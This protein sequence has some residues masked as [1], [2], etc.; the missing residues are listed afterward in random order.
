[1][2]AITVRGLSSSTLSHQP[3]MKCANTK[4]FS[5]SDSD[6]FDYSIS[7]SFHG[8]Y[9]HVSVSVCVCF[10]FLELCFFFTLTTI[11][12]FLFIGAAFVLSNVILWRIFMYSNEFQV[13]LYQNWTHVIFIFIYYL[14][15]KIHVDGLHISIS[16]IEIYVYSMQFSQFCLG[17]GLQA[18]GMCVSMHNDLAILINLF[19]VCYIFSTTHM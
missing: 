12:F 9:I 5:F 18:R 13:D 2:L 17:Y 10:F 1:M 3:A 4:R 15:Y 6:G 8:L 11:L 7:L 19:H 14:V 16:N